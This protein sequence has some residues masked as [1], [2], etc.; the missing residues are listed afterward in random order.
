MQL[1]VAFDGDPETY[2]RQAAHR[3]IERPPECPN[4]GS[5][6][7]LEAHGYYPRW[8]SAGERG[9]PTSIQVRRFRCRACRRTASMLPDFAQPYRV[10]ATD[11][12]GEFLAGSRSGSTMIPWLPL[13]D[14]YQRRFEARLPETRR[15]LAAVFGMD[16]LDGVAVEQWERMQRHFGGARPLTIRMAGEAGATVWGIYRC[17]LPGAAGCPHTT[18]L[19]PCWRS[20]PCSRPAQRN[21]PR[22]ASRM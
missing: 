10:V 9:K 5:E 6:R 2:V 16:G 1:I 17:H 13:L 14:G 8:V 20:P 11:T 15:I 22:H 4:C 12:V 18:I 19:S 21:E 7:C 3:R